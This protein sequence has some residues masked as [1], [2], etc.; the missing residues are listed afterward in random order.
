MFGAYPKSKHSREFRIS[1]TYPPHAEE[2]KHTDQH[3]ECHSSTHPDLH[4]TE[5][6]QRSQGRIDCQKKQNQIIADLHRHEIHHTGP[7]CR[8]SKARC[9]N[10]SRAGGDRH[11]SLIDI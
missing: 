3:S 11:G 2:A 4:R 7:H 8:C 6:G 1:T 10:E 5:P 9:S